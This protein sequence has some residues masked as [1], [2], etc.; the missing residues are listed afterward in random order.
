M[1]TKIDEIDEME[2]LFKIMISF[3]L[4][5]RGYKGVDGM[6][7]TLREYL[8]DLEGSSKRKVGEVSVIIL[9][10]TMRCFLF[11][12]I[13]ILFNGKQGDNGKMLSYIT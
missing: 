9:L 6:K 7:T 4:S 13:S 10:V 1:S 12:E 5:T 8:E 2:D 11:P 3:G